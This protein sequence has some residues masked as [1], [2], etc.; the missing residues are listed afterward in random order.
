MQGEVGAGRVRGA[1]SGSHRA[2]LRTAH[3]RLPRP[4]EAPAS[5]GGPGSP[6]ELSCPL[7]RPRHPLGVVVAPLTSAGKASRDRLELPVPKQPE[8]SLASALPGALSITALCTALAEP[9]WLHIHGGTCSRQELGVSDVLGYVHPDLLKGWALSLALVGFGPHR[10]TCVVGEVLVEEGEACRGDTLAQLKQPL[11]L[12]VAVLQE[13]GH[14]A[15]QALPNNSP[16]HAFTLNCGKE[17]G[18]SSY[19]PVLQCATVTGFSYWASELILAQQQQHKKYH[20]SQ[21]YVTFAV[22]FYLV[23]GAGGASILATAANLLRHYPTEEEEQALELL[24][25]MEENEP[26]PAEYEV[27]NQFQPPPAY[28]P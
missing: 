8:R 16:Y 15:W 19:G 3:S 4:T 5:A 22:S 13:L 26:Y 18:A 21:V 2:R 20:G 24:S 27:I 7:L 28:T 11:A 10:L 23:A 6:R 17:R 9:A 25:E 1:D 14:H 12:M